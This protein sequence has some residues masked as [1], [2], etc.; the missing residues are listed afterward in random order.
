MRAKPKTK[1]NLTE[2]SVLTPRMFVVLCLV[3]GSVGIAAIA[4]TSARGGSSI[5]INS[6]DSADG[7]AHPGS[8]VTFNW[9]TNN[10]NNNVNRYYDPRV[11]VACVKPENKFYWEAMSGPTPPNPTFNFN[12]GAGSNLDNM[13][14]SNGDGYR[15]GPF[16]STWGNIADL[17]NTTCT[18]T[19]YHYKSG[20]GSRHFD[21]ASVKFEVYP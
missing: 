17:P 11:Y 8:N 6:I 7:K 18:A 21:L 4:I 1:P 9:S 5:T 19:L 13:N 20:Q 3:F 2:K 14:D 15:D 16:Y 12:I 10:K